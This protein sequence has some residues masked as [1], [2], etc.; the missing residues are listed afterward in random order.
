MPRYQWLIVGAGFTGAT[1]AARIA[2]ELN[3]KVLVI[4]R[5]NHVAGNAFDERDENGILTHR[6]GPHIFHTNSQKVWDFLSQ[7]TAWR[8]Y[9]HRVKAQVDGKLVPLPFNLDAIEMLFP[10]AQAQRYRDSLLRDYGKDSKTPIIKLRQSGDKDIRSLADYIYDKIFLNYTRKQW[11]LTPEQLDPGVTARVPVLIGADDRYFQDRYQAIPAQ[12]YTSM[13]SRM[14][15]H[16]NIDIEL[17]RDWES[18]QGQDVADRMVFTGPID[19]YFGYA[20]GALPYRSLRFESCSLDADLFQPVATI[21]Y[22]NDFDFTRV[23]EMKHLTGERGPRTVLMYEYPQAYR[24][25]ENEPYYPIPTPDS[26]AK[27]KPYQN[28]AGKL[29]GKVWFAGR[30]GDYIY[31]NMDQACARGLSLFDKELS[32]LC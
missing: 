31:Y 16:P 30:L 18:L 2:R 23:T 19:Q 14:L 17:E 20:F 26:A 22:P 15:S 13:I 24:P 28:E 11:D 27:L 32:R 4:D 12:G 9:V 6:Y 10:A 1:V 5:R 7:F 21:N 29:A 8:P 3:Q 25:G